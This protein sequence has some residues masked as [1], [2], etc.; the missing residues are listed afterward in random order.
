M[1]KIIYQ[2][3][4]EKILTSEQDFILKGQIK[5]YFL[6][7]KGFIKYSSG[8]KHSLL[9]PREMIR[10]RFYFDLIEKYQYPANRISFDVEINETTERLA[11]IIVYDD[12]VKGEPFL[13]IECAG[14]EGFEQNAMERAIENAEMLKAKYAI[15]ATKEKYQI[16][17]LEKNLVLKN[18]PIAYGRIK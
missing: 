8:E 18:I 5:G 15:C 6:L 2:M 4:K 17:D 12:T 16:I 13:A 10:A 14:E 1:N 3:V 9:N 11:D 7:D